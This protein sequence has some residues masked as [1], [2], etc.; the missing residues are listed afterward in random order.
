MSAS[1]FKQRYTAIRRTLSVILKSSKETVL[2]SNVPLEIKESISQT[3]D[4]LANFEN[5]KNKD[6]TLPWGAVSVLGSIF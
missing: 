3:L 4:K 6:N 1:Q 5:F 2:S